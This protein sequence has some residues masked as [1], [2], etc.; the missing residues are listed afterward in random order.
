MSRKDLYNAVYDRLTIFFPE[1]P[2]IKAI[3]K[4]GNNP[5][6]H[7]LGESF[8]SYG[9]FIFH[10]KGLD[11][12]D[13]YDRNAL[14]EAFFYTQKILELYNRIEASKKAHYKARFKAAFEASNDMRAL[15]FETF[16]Y[17]TLVHYG[18][19]VDC[20]D[21]RDAGETYDYLACRDEN[22]VEVECKSFS[23]DKGLVISSGEAQKLASG[24]LNNFT[25]TYEQSKKQLSI[26]TIKVIE[27]LPQNPVMLA[28]V[29]TEICEHIS[30]GQNIQREKYS[31]TT[32]VHFDV[33][34][35]PN[36][37][38]SIIPVKS[39]DMELLCMMPQTTSDD[40]VTCLR[41]TTIS[42]N[43]SWREFEK[44]CKDAAKKQLTKVNP[45]VIVVHVSNLDAISAMLR[46]GRLRLK[47]NNIFNQPHLVEIIL[48]SNSGV[49]ERDKYPY[50]ELRPY[51]RSFTNDR[52]EFEWKI[53]LFSSK[54]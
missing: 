33:P 23:Y 50:L 20:K 30:S 7:T 22:R 28:K 5:P 52:S 14:A 40:S 4:Y 24:I 8:I 38:P 15:A 53:K 2:W 41:I 6:A 35:I 25:A 47:I 16:V 3:E 43:A 46:D 44:T 49:Y 1:Q 37:A 29:C 12:C 32:E 27:K 17:F 36:G 11:S 51:I 42:T 10:T 21:D 45:G 34:D 31:V 9:L 48:V 54:E 19:N 26:V 13:E 18:W 39:S